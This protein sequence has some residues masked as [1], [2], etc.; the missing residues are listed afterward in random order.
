MNLEEL[1]K[2]IPNDKYPEIDKNISIEKNII[3]MI[4]EAYS[5]NRGELTAT[6]QYSYQSFI[7]KPSK[8]LYH[9]AMEEI[10]ELA[11]S[12]VGHGDS[13]VSEAANRIIRC[14]DQFEE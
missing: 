10:S 6:T 1:T 7:L 12:L 8:E 2:F 5:G 13:A 9:K 14:A 4:I 3:P 11:A